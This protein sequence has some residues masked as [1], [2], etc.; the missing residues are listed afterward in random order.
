MIEQLKELMKE[1]LEDEEIFPMIA[2]AMMRMKREL[3]IAGFTEEQAM[4]M[5]VAHGF[6]FNANKN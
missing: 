3:V 2:K 1:F 4:Q 5:L 6:G